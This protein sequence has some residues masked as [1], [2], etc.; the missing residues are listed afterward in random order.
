MERGHRGGCG[1][2]GWERGSGAAVLLLSIPAGLPWPSATFVVRSSR[3]LGRSAG[4]REPKVTRGQHWPSAPPFLVAPAPSVSRP[5]VRT[6]E[7][8][9]H[10]SFFFARSPSSPVRF[11]HGEFFPRGSTRRS[12]SSITSLLAS[13]LL[14]MT[15][16]RSLILS[17][18]SLFFQIPGPWRPNRWREHGLP[19]PTDPVLQLYASGL[20]LPRKGIPTS[21]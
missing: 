13:L 2:H 10:L 15:I 14:S 7:K 11:P 20:S 19:L 3:S 4:R 12:C 6:R 8:G 9:I 5:V 18:L 16:M 17:G 1:S 21:W